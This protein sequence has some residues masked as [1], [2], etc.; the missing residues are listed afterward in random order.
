MDLSGSQFG[1]HTFRVGRTSS[2]DTVAAARDSSGRSVAAVSIENGNKVNDRTEQAIT[3]RLPEGE[4]RQTHTEPNGQIRWA[5]GNM[6]RQRDV[7]KV[8][9]A[10]NVSPNPKVMKAVMGL[11]VQEHGRM[12][13]AD[14]TLTPEGAALSR[15]MSK[16]FG[17]KGHPDNPQMNPTLS[18]F[19]DT[20]SEEDSGVDMKSETQYNNMGWE[21]N[22]MPDAYGRSHGSQRRRDVSVEEAANAASLATRTPKPRQQDFTQ[23]ALFFMPKAK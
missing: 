13:V 5:G 7:D 4:D 15:V 12:P 2:G 10:G 11:A 17:I 18:S 23:G 6:E 14:N 9:W 1:E 19:G 16:K 21:R 3:R 8:Q 22:I 20:G